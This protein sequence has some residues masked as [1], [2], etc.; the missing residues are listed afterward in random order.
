LF[1]LNSYRPLVLPTGVLLAALASFWQSYVVM[2]NHIKE[3]FMP[4]ALLMEYFV[5]TLLFMGAC[6]KKRPY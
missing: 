6:Y 4:F 2:I 5:P 3:G 1:E